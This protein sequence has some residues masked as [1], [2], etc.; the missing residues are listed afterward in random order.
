[1]DVPAVASW[2]SWWWLNSDCVGLRTVKKIDG[3]R[4]VPRG[5]GTH[6]HPYRFSIQGFKSRPCTTRSSKILNSTC[7]N[8]LWNY[9]TLR[10][11]RMCHLKND[12][13][14]IGIQV[15]I[16]I[17]CMN[18]SLL[19]ALPAGWHRVPW[20]PRKQS[21]L[22]RRFYLLG[23]R[24]RKEKDITDGQKRGYRRQRNLS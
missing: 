10:A 20:L 16:N 8:I 23:S 4:G 2:R 12:P 3:R 21:C 5:Q 9:M 7:E 22:S 13:L 17:K 18:I 19:K 1:M 11:L 15:L 24:K 14:S 6:S